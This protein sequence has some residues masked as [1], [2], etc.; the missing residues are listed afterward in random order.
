MHLPTPTLDTWREIAKRYEETWHFPHCIGSLDGKH[1]I[2]QAPPNS[3]SVLFNYKGTFSIVLMALVDADY[4]FVVVDIADYG[5]NSDGGSFANS[6][7]GKAL[8]SKSL[9]VP[10]KEPLLNANKL[11]T[12]PYVIIADEAFPIKTYLMRPYPGR[13]LDDEKRIFNSRLSRARRMVECA[14]GILASRWRI[15]HRRICMLPE[16]VERVVKATVVLH[17]M[18]QGLQDDRRARLEESTR[19]I[20]QKL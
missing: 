20:C 1:I 5:S 10:H 3:R 11:G 13:G 8:E 2:I 6:A 7:L 4:K 9:N 16:N 18:L 14:F 19:K 17:N 12:M 15:F